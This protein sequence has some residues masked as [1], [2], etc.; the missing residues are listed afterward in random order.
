LLPPVITV[1]VHHGDRGFAAPR[2]L[3]DLV[4]TE[5]L[6]RGIARLVLAGLPRFRLSVVDLETLDERE[7][8]ERLTSA[9]ARITLLLLQHV[10]GRPPA[11][12]LAAIARWSGVLRSVARRADG[13]SWLPAVWWY[14]LA[15]TDVRVPDLR[16][17]AARIEHEEEV[18]S[19]ADKLIAQ[20]RVEGRV[21]GRAELML[22]L[23][24]RRFG[25]VP[26]DVA[27]RIRAAGI[28]ELDRFADRVLDA[29]APA[30]VLDDGSQG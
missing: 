1:I 8:A 2:S 29:S 4:S 11:D 27:A 25:S 3:S 24:N 5:G 17:V 7:I 20:G 13:R 19:T 30:D 23:L 9:M 10:R 18:V 22:R 21:E 16:A 12:A 14:V 15:T 6:D 26:Y 28:D